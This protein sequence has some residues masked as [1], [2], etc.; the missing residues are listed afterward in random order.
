M[1]R[2]MQ[3][4]TSLGQ[5]MKQSLVAMKD[6]YGRQEHQEKNQKVIIRNRV[7]PM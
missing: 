4:R 1:Q 3:Q 7:N 2:P 5:A 6:I